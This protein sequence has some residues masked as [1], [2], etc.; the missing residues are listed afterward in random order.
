MS[1]SYVFIKQS[2]DGTNIEKIFVKQLTDKVQFQSELF[3]LTKANK[4][5]KHINCSIL[6]F[7]ISPVIKL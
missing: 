6:F 2:A 4:I 7:I 1:D 5:S 3:G